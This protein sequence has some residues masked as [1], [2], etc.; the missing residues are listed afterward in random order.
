M[1]GLEGARARQDDGEPALRLT[2]IGDRLLIRPPSVTG[3]VD[4]LERLAFV[5]RTNSSQDM[6]AKYVRLTAAGR[7]L[8]ERIRKDRG[9]KIDHSQ[10][11]FGQG[12]G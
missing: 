8:Y 9:E 7:E 4:R 10:G 5:E 3:V 12:A 2:D 1:G 6:R 11:A